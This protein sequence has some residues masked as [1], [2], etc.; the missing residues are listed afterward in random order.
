MLKII[1]EKEIPV[2]HTQNKF[3]KSAAQI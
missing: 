3:T 1:P 2:P